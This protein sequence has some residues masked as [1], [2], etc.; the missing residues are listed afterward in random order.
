MADCGCGRSPTGKCVGWHD[1]SEEAYQ[2]KKA[3]WEKRQ[4]EKAAK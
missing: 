1:L 2:A 4:A 3:E